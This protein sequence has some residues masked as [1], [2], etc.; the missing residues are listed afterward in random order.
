MSISKEVDKL[1]VVYP[2]IILF[3]KKKR[4]TTHVIS[5]MNLKIIS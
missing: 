3:R 4:P 1:I 2:K 5:L